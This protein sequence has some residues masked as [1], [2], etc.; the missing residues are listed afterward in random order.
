MYV[1]IAFTFSGMP[2]RL[3]RFIHSNRVNVNICPFHGIVTMNEIDICVNVCCMCFGLWQSVCV[4]V[5]VRRTLE[6]F[7]CTSIIIHL[8]NHLYSLALHV[9]RGRFFSFVRVS[10]FC[11]TKG[12]V[13]VMCHSN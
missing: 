12:I 7:I 5:C 8:V 1:N 10:G 4:C 6:P 3:K 11:R 9:F 2:L 13:Y